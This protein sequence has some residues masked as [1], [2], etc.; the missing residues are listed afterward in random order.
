[1][2]ASP[3]WRSCEKIEDCLPDGRHAQLWRRPPNSFFFRPAALRR[4]DWR[5]TYRRRDHGTR[6]RFAAKSRATPARSQAL[7]RARDGWAGGVRD[8]K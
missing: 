8:R 2:G 7:G 5:K 6:S 4:R 3:G 1:M